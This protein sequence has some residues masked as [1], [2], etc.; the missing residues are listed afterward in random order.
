V[1]AAGEA[2]SQVA[3]TRPAAARAAAVRRRS[4][5][6]RTARTAWNVVGIVLFLIMVFP[7]YWMI[8]TAFKP[9]DD[10]NRSSPSWLPLHGT[11]AHFRDAIHRP[12]F[13]SSVEN[14]LIIVA[15]TVAVAMVLAFLAA[16]ALAKFRFSGRAI[17]I[18]LIIGIQMLPPAGL[19]I[20]L[21]V[22]LA[23]YP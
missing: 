11:L 19:I 3:V 12:Y 13:W 8:T 10:I 4:R 23:R 1:S 6:R 2:A 21:Y 18:V 16:I 17:F 9:D 20:P 15:V 22:V 14:S 7:V 5:R